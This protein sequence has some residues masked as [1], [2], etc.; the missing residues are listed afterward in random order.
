MKVR[1]LKHYS[2]IFILLVLTLF[3]KVAAFTNPLFRQEL[4]FEPKREHVVETDH[5]FKA[6]ISF[7]I[8]D[9]KY[10]EGVVKILEFGEGPRSKFRGHDKLFGKGSIWRSLW[11]YLKS[12]DLPVWF[13]T[14]YAHSKTKASKFFRKRIDHK[15][16]NQFGW[17]MVKSLSG[18]KKDRIFSQLHNQMARYQNLNNYKGIVILK[19]YRPKHLSSNFL[20][21]GH[22]PGKCKTC[23]KIQNFKRKYRDF[24]ILDDAS[25]FYIS[26]KKYTNL[27]FKDPTLREYRPTCKLYSKTYYSG[28]S[29][30]IKKDFQDSNVVV[31]KPV[32]S[33]K[34]YGVIVVAKTDL[35]RVLKTILLKRPLLARTKDQ[36]YRYWLRDKNKQFIVESY[37]SSKTILVNGKEYD[38]TM[39]VVFALRHDQGKMYVTFLGSYW[40]LP[41]ISLS[42]KGTLNQRTKSAIVNGRMC[43]THV[44]DEDDEATKEILKK[45]L[46]KLYVKML[47][48]KRRFLERT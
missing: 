27:L 12:L 7:V 26:N 8:A 35:Q 38:P 5:A 41:A 48:V 4:I 16:Y 29:E 40:K 43:S 22:N 13:V 36:S 34:G 1:R 6:D 17:R 32:D 9:L 46:P 3:C 24:L 31:I 25:R 14:R 19:S 2:I 44:S 45:I 30:R 21:K 23:R 42:G 47:Q 15:T 18:L 39:R 33:T 28:L 11:H 10:R 37:E 20:M